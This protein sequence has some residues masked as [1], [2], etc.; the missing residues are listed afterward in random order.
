MS[1]RP[2]FGA[3]PSGDTGR[4]GPLLRR[5]EASAFT[6]TITRRRANGSFEIS[7][8][9]G[10]SRSKTPLVKTISCRNGATAAT[11]VDGSR[12]RQHSGHAAAIDF[13]IRRGRLICPAG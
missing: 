2:Y 9:P 6:P 11:M 7:N 8:V 5:T 13:Q 3:L 12:S 1:A 4:E 10:W